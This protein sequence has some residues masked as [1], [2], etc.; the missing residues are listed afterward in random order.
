MKKTVLILL[1]TL[2]TV[3]LWAVDTP[4]QGLGFQVGFA[5]PIL[6]LNDPTR[7]PKDSLMNITTLN[8]LKVG[9]VYDASYI[10][11]FGS[12]LGINYTFAM[13][14]SGWAQKDLSHSVRS[15]VTYHEVEVFVDWQY[16][17]EVAKETYLMLTSGPTVQ[18]GISFNTRTDERDEF[19]GKITSTSMNRYETDN[20]NQRLQH[21]N[22]TWG[23]GAG[24]QYKRYFLRGGYDF[25]LLVPYKNSHFVNAL[26]ETTDRYTR[27]RLDQWSIKIGA[28][29]WYHE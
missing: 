10:A 20:A 12:M 15:M 23:I 9:V 17:F 2:F 8:G 1:T 13:N 19:F 11:G 21:I 24:F 25:G 4:K 22:V 6:R 14:Q 28:Y 7:T 3:S 29:L 18:Y 26:G 16:K 5:R 27:G